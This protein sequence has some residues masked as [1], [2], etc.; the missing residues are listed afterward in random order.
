MCGMWYDIS[1]WQEQRIKMD[2]EINIHEFQ[3]T[4]YIPHLT[5]QQ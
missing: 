2:N 5:Y 4:S 1:K 3:L